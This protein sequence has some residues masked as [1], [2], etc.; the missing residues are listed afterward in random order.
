MVWL[1]M[2]WDERTEDNGW[3]ILMHCHWCM[4]AWTTLA[5]GAWGYF[6]D[7]HISW[8]FFNVWLAGSYVAAM[9]VERDEV[10]D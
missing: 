7:L 9:I 4:S 2:K 8:W 5:V 10:V 3:N 6:S 1:R